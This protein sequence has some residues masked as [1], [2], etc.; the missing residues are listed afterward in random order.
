LKLP[1]R[2]AGL[3]TKRR[4]LPPGDVNHPVSEPGGARQVL[5]ELTVHEPVFAVP[6]DRDRDML[7]SGATASTIATG[8]S[9]RDSSSS[10]SPQRATL[11]TLI[12]KAGQPHRSHG[13]SFE[14]YASSSAV[15]L[16]VVGTMAASLRR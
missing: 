3:M 5:D 13:Q 1:A 2:P 16:A 15:I 11:I 10:Q 6:G 4:G 9:A 12:V 8:S 14:G 7:R